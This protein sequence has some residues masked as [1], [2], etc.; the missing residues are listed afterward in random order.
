MTCWK[1]KQK[2]Q[3]NLFFC[4]SKTVMLVHQVQERNQKCLFPATLTRSVARPKEGPSIEF[5][6]YLISSTWDMPWKSAEQQL[7]YFKR[8]YDDGVPHSICKVEPSHPTVEVYFCNLCPKPYSFSHDPYLMGLVD[9]RSL[10]YHRPESMFQI[11][12]GHTSQ[13]P[14]KHITVF[15]IK[16]KKVFDH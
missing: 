11:S 14:W 15:E 10:A 12:R 5:W 1:T 4:L 7:F 8:L 6:V 3:P 2:F 16:K 13:P 9:S